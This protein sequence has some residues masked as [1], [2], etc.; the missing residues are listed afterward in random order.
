MLNQK[1]KKRA[2]HRAKILEGQMRGLVKAIEEEKYCVDLLTQTLS[3]KNS[4]TS[5]EALLL[6]NHLR[7]HVKHQ[8]QSSKEEDKAVTELLKIYLLSNK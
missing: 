1:I 7:S 5:L 3:I 6:E 4:L 2:I 8:L